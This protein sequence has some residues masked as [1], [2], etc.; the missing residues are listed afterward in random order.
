MLAPD[1]ATE[2]YYIGR[3]LAR[4][5][6]TTAISTEETNKQRETSAQTQRNTKNRA[7]TQKKNLRAYPLR[8]MFSQHLRSARKTEKKRKSMPF[9]KVLHFEKH[10]PPYAH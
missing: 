4:S 8:G 2:A 3:E 6:R 1:E 10:P 9:R 5:S 7:Q